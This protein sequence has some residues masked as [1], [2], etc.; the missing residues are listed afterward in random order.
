M[1]RI[2]TFPKLFWGAHP[3]NDVRTLVYFFEKDR[4][5]Q[6]ITT[7]DQPT[8]YKVCN[9]VLE[10][11]KLVAECHQHGRPAICYAFNPK[12]KQSEVVSFA[13][14]GPY[15]EF[16]RMRKYVQYV[17]ETKQDIFPNGFT[18]KAIG[19]P[20]IDQ[21]ITKT[22]IPK[23][24]D[25]EDPLKMVVKVKYQGSNKLYSFRCRKCHLKGDKV[26]VFTS[27]EYKNVIVEETLYMKESE[28]IVLAKSFGYDD[29][30][31]VYCEEAVDLGDY[32][33]NINELTEMRKCFA[34]VGNINY[35]GDLPDM[36]DMYP[37]GY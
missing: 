31:E 3:L 23:K 5:V 6:T 19:K 10:G 16:T 35:N 14:V 4:E 26:C 29:L 28:I 18:L 20:V 22:D 1:K 24:P 32:E 34:P 7:Q 12:T 15:V 17:N 27:G 36:T 8:K 13:E 33:E 2:K 37:D 9:S 30:A 21:V 11:C 25:K